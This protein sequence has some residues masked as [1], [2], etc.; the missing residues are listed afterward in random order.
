MGKTERQRRVEKN[1]HD[2]HNHNHNVNDNNKSFGGSQCYNERPFTGC[3]MTMMTMLLG[4]SAPSR[5][6]S[7]VAVN[8]RDFDRRL[9]TDVSCRISFVFVLSLWG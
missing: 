3:V 2:N 4:W 5:S 9:P 1:N 8:A 6:L 7:A